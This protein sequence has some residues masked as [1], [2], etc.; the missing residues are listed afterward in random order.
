MRTS[1]GNLS[2]LILIHKEKLWGQT[3]SRKYPNFTFGGVLS[4]IVQW[5]RKFNGIFSLEIS[6]DG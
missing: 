3:Y 6:S 5:L 1:P 4:I 2:S